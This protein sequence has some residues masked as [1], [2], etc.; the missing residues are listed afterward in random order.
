MR[1]SRPA[2]HQG[3]KPFSGSATD[4]MRPPAAV[5]RE[6]SPGSPS[7][8]C[9]LPGLGFAVTPHP[10]APTVTAIIDPPMADVD[11]LRCS[12]TVSGCGKYTPEGG[13]SRQQA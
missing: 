6:S 11:I 2:A 12:E 4:S 8:G 3:D 5:R 10:P 13:R 7:P 1:H 9:E